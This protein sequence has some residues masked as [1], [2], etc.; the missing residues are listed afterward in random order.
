MDGEMPK[1]TQGKKK[2][3]GKKK[4]A[5]SGSGS[6]S[7]STSASASTS[8]GGGGGSTAATTPVGS[9]VVGNPGGELGHRR[10]GSTGSGVGGHRKT[11]SVTGTGQ[12]VQV[13]RIVDTNAAGSSGAS[14]G[15]RPGTPAGVREEDKEN[16]DVS[17]AWD[18]KKGVC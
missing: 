5:G 10:T 15:E 11:G 8:T 2:A 1:R 6:G 16:G 17:F 3:A 18:G 9:P 13:L 12:Q 7:G 14:G 4:K